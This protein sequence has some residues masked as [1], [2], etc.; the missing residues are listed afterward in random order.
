MLVSFDRSS[1]LSFQ[2]IFELG[3]HGE[4]WEDSQSRIERARVNLF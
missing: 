2:E 1:T 4:D 3:A